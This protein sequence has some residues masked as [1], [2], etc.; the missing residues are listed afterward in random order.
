MLHPGKSQ[1]NPLNELILICRKLIRDQ[2]NNSIPV[3]ERP[4]VYCGVCSSSGMYGGGM[5]R[6]DAPVGCEMIHA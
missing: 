3:K 5:L 1:V 2:F 6:W 4:G